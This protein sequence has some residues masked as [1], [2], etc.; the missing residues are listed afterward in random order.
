MKT[1]RRQ[2]MKW[3]TEKWS[4]FADT[5]QLGVLRIEVETWLPAE[6]AGELA[7]TILLALKWAKM[8]DR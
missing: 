2:T 6:D 5:Q 3:H 7:D 1:E 4:V 8:A